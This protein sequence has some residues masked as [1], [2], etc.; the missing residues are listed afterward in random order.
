MNGKKKQP[1]EQYQGQSVIKLQ[2]Y[3]GYLQI[4]NWLVLIMMFDQSE[5]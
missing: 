1:T 3:I 4:W 2:Y 5:A